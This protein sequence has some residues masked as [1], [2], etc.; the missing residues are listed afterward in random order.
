VKIFTAA[1][2]AAG[3]M[4]AGC[5]SVAIDRVADASDAARVAAETVICRGITVGA[6]MRAYGD[7]PSR[8]QAWRDLCRDGAV[9]TP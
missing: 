6:W 2:I 1:G 7:S 4:V 8:A 5:S 3:V 9:S